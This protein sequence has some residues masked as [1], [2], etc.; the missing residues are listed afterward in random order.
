MAFN[1]IYIWTDI[2]YSRLINVANGDKATLSDD[3]FVRTQYMISFQIDL[4]DL[5][6]NK[7]F[8]SYFYFIFWALFCLM[9]AQ[10]TKFYNH[11][12]KIY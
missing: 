8:E 4:I 11:E 7:D 5:Y 3:D 12:W 6:Y 2:A 10:C 9:I 1:L